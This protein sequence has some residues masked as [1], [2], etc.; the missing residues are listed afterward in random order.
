M[1]WD[2]FGCMTQSKPMLSY[3]YLETKKYILLKYDSKYI[4][5]VK[6]NLVIT[7]YIDI[8]MYMWF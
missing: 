8:H 6:I 3:G 1:F 5:V 4:F 7:K 2:L